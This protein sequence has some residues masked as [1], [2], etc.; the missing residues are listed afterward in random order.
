MA[1]SYESE[2]IKGGFTLQFELVCHPE[3]LTKAIDL[4]GSRVWFIAITYHGTNCYRVFWRR[5]GSRTDAEAAISE[6]PQSLRESKPVVISIANL[7]K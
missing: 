4:G 5:F 6:I 1:R 2:L 3:S 7:G